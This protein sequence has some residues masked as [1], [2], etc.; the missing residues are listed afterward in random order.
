MIEALKLIKRSNFALPTYIHKVVGQTPKGLYKSTH[1]RIK[2]VRLIYDPLEV[3]AL[4]GNPNK[5]VV[6]TFG[7]SPGDLADVQVR[8]MCLEHRPSLTGAFVSA[9]RLSLLDPGTRLL[10]MPGELEGNG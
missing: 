10:K 5:V 6:D 8:I 2:C 3:A 9:W 7:A 1:W 4:L